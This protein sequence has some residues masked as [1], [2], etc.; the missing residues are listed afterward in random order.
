MIGFEGVMKRTI[1]VSFVVVTL[2]A[3]A[4]RSAPAQSREHQQ[5]AAELRM[6]QERSQETA[7]ALEKALA[8]LRELA[9][10]ADTVKSINS[11]LDGIDTAVR[12]SLADQKVVLDG[13]G[14]EL[15]IIRERAQDTNTRIGTLREEFNALGT[16]MS[17][18]GAAVPAATESPAASPEG[19]PSAAGASSTTPANTSKSGLSPTRLYDTAWADYSSGN[20]TLA[21]TGFQQFLREYPKYDKADDAQFYVAESY[22]KLKRTPEAITAYNMV[23]QNY[24]SGNYTAEAYYR[25]GEA[26]RSLGQIEAARTSWEAVLKKYPDSDSGI[27]AKQRLDGLPPPAAPRQP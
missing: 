7:L 18:L 12:K 16:A 4:P 27:L 20:Y 13:M 2:L 6:L 1:A 15:R 19:V 26:Q 22:M 23:I 14:T 3:A 5:M 9:Q 11:R 17:M 21:I 8:L 24:A 10:V 25:L